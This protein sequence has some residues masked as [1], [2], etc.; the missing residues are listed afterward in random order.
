[1]QRKLKNIIKHILAI[2]VYNTFI[3]IKEFNDRMIGH[4]ILSQLENKGKHCMFEGYGKIYKPNKLKIGN[5][6]FIGR[7]FFIR[8]DGGILIG[9]YTHISRNVTI[10]TVNH[11]ISG[12]MLPY[13]KSEIKKE[14]IIGNYVWIGMNVSILSGVTIGD[15]AVVGMGAIVSKNVNPGEI[16]VSSQQ[17]VIGNRDHNHTNSLLKQNMFLK[18][19]K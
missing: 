12:G 10:H 3:R 18:L 5:H 17:R 9:D 14:V 7:N 19:N 8:S 15:G 6:V 11:N 1:M 16:I 4:T 2:I 13:D